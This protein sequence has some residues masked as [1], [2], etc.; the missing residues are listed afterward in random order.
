VRYT[1][2]YERKVRVAAFDMLT[3][4]LSEE[5]DDSVMPK[6]AAFDYVR[7]RV[8]GWVEEERN[9]LLEKSFPDLTREEQPIDQVHSLR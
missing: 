1:V 4:G 9:R 8:D 5:F 7:K 3:I 6:D 2:F